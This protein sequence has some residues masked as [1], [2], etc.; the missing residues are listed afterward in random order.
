MS[1]PVGLPQ[2]PADETGE[3]PQLLADADEA[4]KEDLDDSLAAVPLVINTDAPS[5]PQQDEDN[6]NDPSL[7]ADV[8][9]ELLDDT[10]TGPATLSASSAGDTFLPALSSD[11]DASLD[12]SSLS[13]SNLDSGDPLDSVANKHRRGKKIMPVAGNDGKSIWQCPV[14]KEQLDTDHA[15]T[16]H[17]RS[18]NSSQPAQQPNSCTICFKVLSSASSLDRHM[19]VHSGERPFRCKVCNQAF[20][21]N[22]NMHRHSR[23]HDKEELK[24][25]QIA[26]AAA[27]NGSRTSFPLMK[28]KKRSSKAAAASGA[29]VPSASTPSKSNA[30]SAA[31]DNSSW[32]YSKAY[33]PERA[34]K[35]TAMPRSGVDLQKLHLSKIPNFLALPEQPVDHHLNTHVSSHKP[36]SDKDQMSRKMK[37]NCEEDEELEAPTKRNRSKHSVVHGSL[38]IA[39]LKET[40]TGKT[41]DQLKPSSSINQKKT[42][43]PLA[44]GI[45]NHGDT[46]SPSFSSSILQTVVDLRMNPSRIHSE[47]VK[48]SAARGE[49][50]D[51]QAHPGPSLKDQNR[52]LVEHLM[53]EQYTPVK[54]QQRTPV[55]MGRVT[56]EARIAEPGTKGKGKSRETSDI[57]KLHCAE[58]PKTFDSEF[59]MEV[60]KLAYHVPKSETDLAVAEALR[61]QGIPDFMGNEQNGLEHEK[62]ESEKDRP[63]HEKN[64]VI[65]RQ[66]GRLSQ[67]NGLSEPEEINGFSDLCF[68]DCTANKFVLVAKHQCEEIPRKSNSKFHKFECSNCG[69]CFPTPASLKCHVASHKTAHKW[70]KCRMCNC[71][72]VNK[73]RLNA[74]LMKHVADKAFDQAVRIKDEE[75]KLGMP[76]SMLQPDFMAMLGLM[77]ANCVNG[78]DNLNEQV[79]DSIS[80][81]QNNKYYDNIWAAQAKR[82]AEADASKDGD[83]PADGGSWDG[84]PALAPPAHGKPFH[85]SPTGPPP[86]LLPS[87]LV[88]ANE[89]TVSNDLPGGIVPSLSPS[90]SQLTLNGDASASGSLKCQ[91]CDKIFANART[92]KSHHR[93]HLGLSP[94]KCES[95][96]YASADKSTLIRHMRTHNGQ[97]PYKCKK[98][99]FAFT[100]KAN[101]ERH[102]RKRH[103]VHDKEEMEKVVAFEDFSPELSE[104]L[105]SNFHSPDTICQYCGVDF[106]YFRHLKNHM[107]THSR[108]QQKPFICTKCSAGFSMKANAIRHMQ[109]QHKEVAD[110]DIE[111]FITS[112][113]FSYDVDDDSD[114]LGAGYDT[115]SPSSCSTPGASRSQSTPPL[116]HSTPCGSGIWR[117][118]PHSDGPLD[119][120]LKNPEIAARLMCMVPQQCETDQPIDLTTKAKSSPYS[121]SLEDRIPIKSL[122]PIKT[123]PGEVPCSL[124]T[125]V[126]SSNEAA[127]QHMIDVHQVHYLFPSAISDSNNNN[128]DAAALAGSVPA[129]CMPLLSP[130]LQM[131]KNR[132]L[133]AAGIPV[134]H[135]HPA[136]PHA[137][138]KLYMVQAQA[139]AQAKARTQALSGP[140]A[141]NPAIL[142]SL[143]AASVKKEPRMSGTTTPVSTMSSAAN[144]VIGEQHG[145]NESSCDLA[146]VNKILESTA[147]QNIQAFLRPPLSAINSGS[148]DSSPDFPPADSGD[149][150]DSDQ[151]LQ[152]M[153]MKSLN[154]KFSLPTIKTEPMELMGQ[155]KL[156][157]R[158]NSSLRQDEERDEADDE[159]EES[160]GRLDLSEEKQKGKRPLSAESDTKSESDMS[161]TKTESGHP[162]KKKRNSYA[163]SPHKLYCPKCP[164]SF[165][166]ISSLNRHMLTH[167]G[168]KPFTCSKCS[169]TFSTKSNRE[170]HLI[171]KHGVNMLDPASRQTMDRP[172]KCHLCVFSSF[173]TEGNLLKHYKERH[174]RDKPPERYLMKGDDENDVGSEMDRMDMQE[175][176]LENSTMDGWSEDEDDMDMPSTL[177]SSSAEIKAE[178]EN[179]STLVMKEAVT[180]SSLPSSG[181][182]IPTSNTVTTS[183]TGTNSTTATTPRFTSSAMDFR[184]NNNG[185]DDNNDDS[186]DMTQVSG[187]AERHVNP[188]RDNYNVDKI[189]YCW[190]CA[191]QF[192]SRKLLVRHLKEHNIDLPFK[193]YLCDASYCSRY[194]CLLHQEKNHASDWTILKDKNG[195]DSIDSYSERL[196]RVVERN[197]KTGL[198]NDEG[199]YGDGSVTVMVTGEDGQTTE[200][201]A[202]DYLQRKVYCSLCSKRFWSLQDLRRH[203]RSHTGERPFECDKCQKRFTLKHSMMRHRR[204]HSEGDNADSP[205]IFSDEED[206]GTEIPSRAPAANPG[207]GHKAL[208]QHLL[209]AA[210]MRAAKIP[211][212]I[213][214]SEQNISS[215]HAAANATTTINNN[216]INS[217]NDEGD[218]NRD[219]ILH[220]LLGVESETIDQIFEAKVSAASLLGV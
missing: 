168:Q 77:P 26:D 49:D 115:P 55:L 97:R 29:S 166:W 57:L 171:R 170:R 100:T 23:I 62:E 56:A 127:L 130:V 220:N 114:N 37:I 175:N 158:D 125:K 178:L 188:E 101:C 121:F 196:D 16:V 190:K 119:F 86:S 75:E 191:D 151:S 152:Q 34:P 99:D 44:K 85:F 3:D 200:S 116:A 136:F 129:S 204:K 153:Y 164:R 70:S 76:G 32:H 155:A 162:V 20:T 107:K 58:C 15:L 108:C 138:Q 172:Y 41:E 10:G 53:S 14:C 28:S 134:F 7:K 12:R 2:P 142:A 139:Q 93:S 217:I 30:N 123:L 117:T 186:N 11:N 45:H 163:D 189:T 33:N 68:M 110:T 124:C 208:R 65:T 192:N 187:P 218:N 184:A 72:F 83:K 207:F 181:T 202:S 35:L 36:I 51:V 206:E 165:P 67:E 160:E 131:M 109:K 54:W 4:R 113:E 219:D 140:K 149:D 47:L 173:S 73:E 159:G 194:E 157:D 148:D 141:L 24:A 215:L 106:K 81:E 31:A 183:S 95:C 90:P 212:S 132:V 122:T 63:A 150:E 193:C 213:Q 80:K 82:K 199:D 197:C 40:L 111:N 9:E 179:V 211:L 60:H 174:P 98:C 39:G 156:V 71:S 167:T 120:S 203:M 42:L 128:R 144:S 17:I 145:N 64:G 79:L 137:Q 104:N 52:T 176:S 214:T 198:F 84:S 61:E 92:L 112:N 27:Q 21:T 118:L 48:D 143:T 147:N 126:L 146:S 161:G 133:A 50:R 91:F 59:Q 88:K 8:T 87:F 169:V 201:V 25:A 103:H 105:D 209:A 205:T 66:T 38:D 96:D 78:H 185:I 69:L 1:Y 195:V 13:P 22:G 210:V 102:V 5:S 89:L 6:D 94:Y 18:H 180:R 43:M 19:L 135:T 182:V 177:V 216:T 46:V 154:G 74:H